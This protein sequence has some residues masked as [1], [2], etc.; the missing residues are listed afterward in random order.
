MV[1]ETLQK[2]SN[3]GWEIDAEATLAP[4]DDTLGVL[5]WIHSNA[6]IE[7]FKAA[8]DGGSWDGG[9]DCPVSAGSFE[10]ALTAA[11]LSLR[12]ALDMANG[13]LKRA[14]LVTRP[15]SHH[16]EK[17][18]ARGY[19]Y[20]NCVALA[21]EVLVRAWSRPILIVD[22]DAF[23][24]NGTQL[25]FYDRADVGYVSVHEFPAF[26]GTGGASEVGIRAGIGATRN[27][28]LAAGATDEI[29]SVALHTAIAE[30]GQTMQPA[31]IVVSA[32]FGGHRDDP[33]GGLKM[34]TAGFG[35][36]TRTI[37]RAAETWSEGR[38]LSLLEGGFHP[39]ALPES[40]EAHVKVLA[41]TSGVGGDAAELGGDKAESC[42]NIGV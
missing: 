9:G 7:R 39:V 19:C 20:F 13:K 26:P 31:A 36:L 32:G 2:I 1:L 6:Y 11:Q 33:V 22:F 34:T 29:V 35:H 24:G 16:A 25:H 27:V 41:G 42:Q 37:V 14:F 3:P 21:A 30:L 17:D 18:R 8:T 38:I 5:K 12:A 4:A 10:A 40:V 28:P 15:P 23:H